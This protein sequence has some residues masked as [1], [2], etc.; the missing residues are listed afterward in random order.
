M[1]IIIITNTLCVCNC[2]MGQ[3]QPSSDIVGR[4]VSL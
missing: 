2:E 1:I 4:E 3:T